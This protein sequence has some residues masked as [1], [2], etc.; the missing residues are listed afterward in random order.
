MTVNA[1]CSLS[2]PTLL[3]LTQTLDTIPYKEFPLQNFNTARV[4][5]RN[6]L[7]TVALIDRPSHVQHGEKLSLTRREEDEGQNLHSRV[8]LLEIKVANTSHSLANIPRVRPKESADLASR[9]NTEHPVKC[10]CLLLF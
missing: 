3:P 2:P 5:V 7:S 9:P 8:V 10:E 6:K 1:L 4:H